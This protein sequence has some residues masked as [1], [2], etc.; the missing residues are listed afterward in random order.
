MDLAGEPALGHSQLLRVVSPPFELAAVPKKAP[1][2]IT[3]DQSYHLYLNGRYVCRGPA[4]GF[5]RS[6]PFDEVDVAAYLRKGKNILAVRAHNGG[7]SSFQYLHQGYASLIVAAQ[8]GRTVLLTDDTWKCRRQ[9]GVNRNTVPASMMLADQEWIDLRVEDPAWLEAGFDDSDWNPK[10]RVYSTLWNAMPWPALEARGIPMLEEKTISPQACLGAAEG[11]CHPSYLTTRNLAVLRGEEGLAHQPDATRLDELVIP[12][13][14]HGAWKSRLIDFGKV[15]VGSVLLEIPDAPD[16][17]IIDTFHVE[18]IDPETLAPHFV[19]LTH[20]RMAFAQRIVC[21]AGKNRHLFY[22]AYGFRYL[23]LTVRDSD[24]PIKIDV[25]LQTALYPME[26]KGG[27][28]SSEPLLEKIW[29]ACAWTQRLCSLDAY[30][31]TPWR[32]QAQW[33]GDARVQG[34]N[35]FHY[36][37]DTRLFRR[38]LKQIASQTTPHGLTYGHSPTIAHNCVLPDFTLIWMATLWDYAWQT[39]SIEPFLEHQEVLKGALAYFEEWTDPKNGLLRYDDRFW[40]FLDWTNLQIDGHSGVYSQWLLYALD[41]IVL[42]YRQARM[43]TEAARYAKWAAG[44]RRSLRKLITPRGLVSDGILPGGKLNPEC[45]IHSQTLAIMNRLEPKL[46]AGMLE[47]V[48]R[49][50]L[51][52]DHAAPPGEGWQVMKSGPSAYWVTYVYSVLTERGYGAEV[53]ADIANQWAPMA[54][55]GTAF[56]RFHG[57]LGESSRSHAWSAH[58]LFHFMQVLGGV[59]Q[60]APGWKQVSYA[61][62]FVGDRAEVVYPAPP[63]PIESSW[64]RSGDK[65]EAVLKLPKGVSA[66]V[67]LPGQRPRVVT[68]ANRFVIPAGPPG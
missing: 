37:G 29:D 64:K 48:L 42:M 23:V 61:P 60:L 57:G 41:R 65:I 49:P 17:A 55:F 30:V 67:M 68:G 26:K 3:A 34:W 13:T 35:T 46:E 20:C 16:G 28:K 36:S 6:W 24:A 19:P 5:Q 58:P 38:G 50:Y 14:G 63:G 40:L 22:H 31:D 43:S 4:R 15:V 59:R 12:A 10:P 9:S 21:R 25:S 54:E 18:T 39:G 56:E 11:T 51:H 45:S 27:F 32:E 8:W 53:V 47:K 7:R 2:F 52:A 1:L 66:R 44:L 33:W 62:E